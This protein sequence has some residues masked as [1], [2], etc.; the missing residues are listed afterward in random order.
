MF[1]VD[2]KNERKIKVDATEKE[3]LQF[4]RDYIKQSPLSIRRDGC[5]ISLGQDDICNLNQILGNEEQPKN[6]VI[7]KIEELSSR[8]FRPGRL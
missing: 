3:Y 4:L 8:T 5:V 2:I 7:K 1:I 6:K